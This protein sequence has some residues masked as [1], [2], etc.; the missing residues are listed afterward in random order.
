M[1][2]QKWPTTTNL[3][4]NQENILMTN[5][6]IKLTTSTPDDQQ[7]EKLLDG[8]QSAGCKLPAPITKARK[9]LDSIRSHIESTL[10]DV[11][12]THR[13]QQAAIDALAVGE[14]QPQQIL[15]ALLADVAADHT[16]SQTRV[17]RLHTI[18]TQ[19]LAK[20]T[21]A[22]LEAA[23]APGDDWITHIMR[24][25]VAELTAELRAAD[26]PEFQINRKENLHALEPLAARPDIAAAWSDLR[27]IYRA[28]S[29]LRSYGCIPSMR[30]D[31]DMYEF[32]GDPTTRGIKLR[33]YTVWTLYV[34]EGHEPGI[35]TQEEVNN[36]LEAHGI[37][38]ADRNKL[39]QEAY[40]AM[41]KQSAPFS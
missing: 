29:Q 28:A 15:E 36:N 22:L 39:Q 13:L 33:T 3:Q 11:K 38:R 5:Q 7:L 23:R 8:L 2:S 17:P 4:Q 30:D 6:A 41:R 32:Q 16:G 27:A 1:T 10:A 37:I 26:I 25:R 24:P 34:R 9:K 19:A 35:Y 31:S 18:R 12:D 21:R 40:E 14:A 20:A